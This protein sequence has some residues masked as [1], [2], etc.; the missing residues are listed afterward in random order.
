MTDVA[1]F[2][3]AHRRVPRAVTVQRRRAISVKGAKMQPW[4]RWN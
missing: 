3:V 1:L 2:E 4:E